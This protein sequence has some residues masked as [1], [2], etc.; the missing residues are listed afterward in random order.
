MKIAIIGAGNV[1]G[2]LA[3]QL[4]KAGHTVLIGAKLP[5]SEK[6]IKLA[7]LIGEDRFTSVEFASKQPETIIIASNPTAIGEISKK[8]GDV[9][10]KVI[11]DAMNS[12][13]SKPAGFENT[14]EVLKS[15][16]NCENVVK[17]FNST[18]FENME[19]P[20]YNGVGIDMF[21]AGSSLKAKEVA[22]QLSKDTGFAE[23][24]DFGGDDNVALLEQFALAWI[25]LA[26]FQKHGRGIALKIIKR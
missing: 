11:I 22:K 23:C 17:C 2:A 25:N 5:L 7:T 21:A 19:N 10:D 1:G 20:I 14:F 8:L 12:I 18:G 9:K 3:R 16:T 26:I 13:S 24:Y 6:S 15:L 4:I